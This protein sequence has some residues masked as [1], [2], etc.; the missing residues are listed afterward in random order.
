MYPDNIIKLCAPTGRAAQRMTES[1][2][3]EAVTI[4]RL[5]DFRPCA[6]GVVHKDA[7][8]PIVAD[9][10]VVDEMSMTDTELMSIFLQAVQDGTL[11]LLVGDIYQL[12][13]V[14]P[15]DVLHDIIFS[16]KVPVF[17]LTKVYRQAGDSP[18]VT[19]AN[20]I[21]D[22]HTDLVENE[23]FEIIIVQ[24]DEELKDKILEL[25]TQY[26]NPDKPF[27]MQIL[28][29]SKKYDAGTKN[30]NKVIQEAVNPGK[31]GF[32]FGDTTYRVGDK[33]IMLNNNYGHGY[34]NG[35]VGY[36]VAIDDNGVTVN[37]LDVEI[38]I[39]KGM[40]EDMSLAYGVTVH[41]SQGSEYPLAIC[42]LPKSPANM[43]VRN[44][45]YTAVTRAKKKVIVV[46]VDGS[47]QA[48]VRNNQTGKRK[49]GLLEKLSKAEFSRGDGGSN[50]NN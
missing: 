26:Y 6:N 8:N 19:N 13:S 22:G 50:G 16:E 35:D 48:S 2:G 34:F 33:I 38:V 24:S 9:L 17:R 10:I 44:L 32:V 47:V 12:P 29:P 31:K 45:F 23:D 37:I 27:D 42:A 25:T 11:V 15:G 1:T 49:T 20:K 3:M 39:T 30:L 21:N 14:G 46:A 41:K 40:M 43:L 5:L 7:K 36:V 28:A 18:I 4:H